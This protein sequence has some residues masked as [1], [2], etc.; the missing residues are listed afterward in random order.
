MEQENL[1]IPSKISGTQFREFAVFDA[2]RRRK[3]WIRP[4]IFTAFFVALAALAFSRAGEKDGAALLGGVLLLVGLGLPAVYFITFFLSVRA[5]ARKIDPNEIAYTLTL[6][7]SGVR[8]QKGGQVSTCA[9]PQLPGACRLK[10]GICLYVDALHALLLPDDE[11][12][13]TWKMIAAR[14]GGKAKDYR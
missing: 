3:S 1:T 6:A 7:E 10:H 14:L 4:A 11:D 2:L 13:T 9:W 5:R 12:G 8:V